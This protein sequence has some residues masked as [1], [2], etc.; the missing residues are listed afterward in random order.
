MFSVEI[1]YVVIL[2]PI[3]VNRIRSIFNQLLY[4]DSESIQNV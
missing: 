2:F 3:F 4:P 1:K